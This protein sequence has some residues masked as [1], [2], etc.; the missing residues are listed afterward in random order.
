MIDGVAPVASHGFDVDADG[1]GSL[2]ADRLYQ[3]ERQ[4]GPMREHAFEIESL[5]R[6]SPPTP[7]RSDRMAPLL[8]ETGASSM[9]GVAPYRG[10]RH[11]LEGDR[12]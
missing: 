1:G 9:L 12:R 10:A 4:A 11:F 8:S 7:S 6:A 5:I 3:L 2:R